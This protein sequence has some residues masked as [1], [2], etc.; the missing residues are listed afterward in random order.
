[1]A[2]QRIIYSNNYYDTA[3]AGSALA[4]TNTGAFGTVWNST[5]GQLTGGKVRNLDTQAWY[6]SRIW[7]DFKGRAIQA[8]S[9]N[10]LGGTDRTDTDYRF[11]GEVN[12]TV[13]RHQK[14][15]GGPTTTVATN[16]T[17]DHMGRPT[18]VSHAIDAAAPTVLASYAY[19]AIGRMQ[20][21][22][23]GGGG[24]NAGAGSAQTGFWTQGSTWQGGSVPG[25]MSSVSINAG[26][27]VTIP[28]N[29][30]VGAGM[31]YDASRLVFE[32]GST[33]KLNGGTGGGNT[34]AFPQTIDY[35]WHI[36]G[37]L[38]GLNLNAGGTPDLTGGKT[39]AMKL[40]YDDAGYYDGNIGSQT[41][42]NGN[43]PTL[44]RSYSYSYDHADRL[45]TATY[46]GGAS[47]ENFT[48][49]N[50]SYDANGNIQTMNRTGVDQLAYRYD[51]AN[52]SNKLL[53]VSDAISNTIGFADGNTSGDDY[54]Y[55]PDGSLKKDLNRG[56]TDI[57]YN[58]LKLPRQ[59]TFS[60]GKVI[61]YQYDAGGRKLKMSVSG[62]ETRDYVGS[63][64][65]LNN[66]LFEI[67][68]EEGRYS[69]TGGY[70]YFHKDHLGN[71]RVAFNASGITQYT[72]YDPWGLPLWGGLSGGSSTNRMQFNGKEAVTELGGGQYDFGARLQDATI[73]R[74]FV[75]D[76]LAEVS[77]RWSP[78]SYAY[79]NPIRYIDIDGLTP[80]DLY[81]QKGNQVGTDNKNDGKVFVVTDKETVKSLKKSGGQVSDAGSVNSATELPSAYV[82]GE[83]GKAVDRSNAANDKRTDEFRGDDN[84]GGFHEEGGV[85]GTGA[86]GGDKVV[87]A[88]PGAK[89]DPIVNAMA[90]VI[91]SEPANSK[92]GPIAADGSFHVHPSGTRNPA[93]N[94]V[95]GS[96]GSFNQS[97]T[98]PQDYNEAKDYPKNS[99]VLGA[100]NGTVS[101][102]NGSVT[103]PV[104]TFP[105]KSF[106]TIGI[107]K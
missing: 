78:Y 51:D 49:N 3:P 99:Y 69:P 30:T 66:A 16:Y 7:Y 94:S 26:H 9:Q 46:G 72:D 15:A 71:V 13:L 92:S 68:H 106:T 14:G 76:P 20:T 103:K 93:S 18:Q 85:Y 88:K 39:F 63:F 6:D 96:S 5:T 90:T 60:S 23:L 22:T 17:Y 70:E 28:A 74:W 59:L 104:A 45:T 36:R 42:L 61:S 4:Y 32:S 67:G 34:G 38:R 44:T 105:L 89:A 43:Q 56:I 27:T 82:R 75:V 48:V 80:G 55:W 50:L 102:Y 87:H 58:L 31:L 24:S 65:Y 35:S 97:P 54:D 101:I 84:E 19:D 47:G 107:K 57:Q 77:R 62:G 10:H 91:P 95:G 41:W 53:A 86:D 40:G 8:Q 25:T 11:N 52:V 73:G 12:Q 79:N 21:K 1:M 37:G 83:M 33:L 64:Q 81:D 100:G 98:D 29:T 2:G